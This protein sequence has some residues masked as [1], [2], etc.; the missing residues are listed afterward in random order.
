MTAAELDPRAKREAIDWF[1]RLS[2]GSATDRER[3]DWQAW[4]AADPAHEQAWSR[5]DGVSR[6]IGDLSAGPPGEVPGALAA[7]TLRRAAPRRRTVLRS[8]AGLGGTV[9]LGYGLYAGGRAM[10]WDPLRDE[11]GGWSAGLLADLRTGV[12]EQRRVELPDG[13][14]LTLNTASAVDVRFDTAMR[15]IRLH[16]GEVHV[17]TA[18]ARGAAGA[19]DPRPL[20][21]ATRLARVRAL[22]TRFLVRAEEDRVS[23]AVLSGAVEARTRGGMLERIDAHEQVAIGALGLEPIRPLAAAADA[24]VEGSLIVDNARLDEVIAEL[25][26]YRRGRL[27]CDPAVA[28][29]RVSGAFPVRDVDQA[30]TAL[31]AALPVRVDRWGGFWTTVK[32]RSG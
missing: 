14:V 27:R 3:A 18:H 22:G 28:G 9:S 5:I 30:L 25:S 11:L 4:R 1:V 29:L 10:G 19:H 24:W 26:R 2:S 15:A 7:S 23:V 6:A 16:E 13:S 12:G 32:A 21:V 20:V 31:S 8:L 17:E